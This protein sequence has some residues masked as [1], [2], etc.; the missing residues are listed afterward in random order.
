[1]AGDLQGVRAGNPMRDGPAYRA[2]ARTAR[3]P[4]PEHR[5]AFNGGPF[6]GRTGELGPYR[7]L[8]I[9]RDPEIRKGGFPPLYNPVGDGAVGVWLL[10]FAEY[11][12]RCLTRPVV[13]VRTVAA[14]LASPRYPVSASGDSWPGGGSSETGPMAGDIPVGPPSAGRSGRFLEHSRIYRFE[15]GGAPEFFIGSA[16]LMTRNLSR[17][18][19]AIAP[20]C[21]PVIKAELEDILR[22]YEQDNCSA[23]DM[24]P[25]G[26]YVRRHPAPGEARRG[27]QQVFIERSAA[28]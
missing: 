19:E 25:D 4:F 21:D 15:N 20:V 10:A 1:V 7:A 12:S 27:A 14:I 2:L 18:V 11:A 8:S 28:R 24:Q 17:R 26:E 6:A 23:W 16:N 5:M 9:R 22:T 13:T 3:P